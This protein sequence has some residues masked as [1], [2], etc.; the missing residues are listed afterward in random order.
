MRRFIKFFVALSLIVIL[1]QGTKLWVYANM[2]LGIDGQINLLGKVLKL[3]YALNPCMAFSID[4][5]FKYSKLFITIL[6]LVVSLYIF[7]YIIELIQ[8][9]A[10]MRWVW[11]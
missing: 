1:D 11:P 6:R 4:L 10:T 2:Q 8:I 7:R 3:T 9:N 5:G